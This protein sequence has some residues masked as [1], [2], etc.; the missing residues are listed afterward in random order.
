MRERK[1]DKEEKIEVSSDKLK[2]LKIALGQIEKNHG[3]GAIMK[4][5]ENSKMLVD[6]IPTGSISLDYALGIGGVPKGRIVE[7]YGPESSGKTT[8]CL[9]IV[10]EA[11]KKGGVAAYI[12]AENSMDPVYARNLGVNIDELLISQPDYGEQALDICDTLVRSNAVDLI[13]VDSV[14]ALVPK[15]EIEGEMGDQF[16]GLQARMMSQAMRKLAAIVNK[17]SC[18]VVFVN[19]LREKIG[20]MFG[21]P[22]T[23]P[24]G[25]ALKFYSSV[26]LDVRRT[27]TLKDG[28]NFLGN[29]VKVKVAKN[30][31]APPFKTAEFDILFGTGISR[32][33]DILDL[34]VKLG[35]LEKSG[36]WIISGDNRWQG[37][38]NARKF[39]K[40]NPAVL[41]D[42]EQK[43]RENMKPEVLDDKPEVEVKEEKLEKVAAK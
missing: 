42:L 35:L 1:E 27:E 10:A 14:A 18:V 11:Q 25:R 17:S 26:R 32:E 12:D 23:T 30:K 38:D 9:H 8:L 20:V 15:T 3:K 5:G 39:L 22:E 43:V 16:M 13:V 6:A 28:E 4:M 19:Q 40:E 7:I 24:G 21:N 33:G 36:S 29:R 34:G 31:V 41:K 37:R 2:A